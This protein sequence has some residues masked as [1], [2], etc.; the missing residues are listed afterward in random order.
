MLNTMSAPPKIGPATLADLIAI[1]E[2][3]RR[4]EIIDGFLVEKGAATY[5]H[6]LAQG[7]VMAALRPYDRSPG[8]R[9]PGGWWFVTEVEIILESSQVFRPDVTG[10]RRDRLPAEP[11]WPVSTKPDWVCE[12]LS[13]N[14]Q[15]DL[16]KKKR[17]LHR[18]G[19]SHYWIIDPIDATL[20]VYRW[21]PDGYIEVLIADRTQRVRAEPF[22]DIELKVGILFGDDDDEEPQLSPQPDPR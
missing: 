20:S 4:H 8:G 11:D 18:H 3:E 17:A 10:W 13:T 19:V 5:P 9:F 1:P 2:E 15:N 21:H 12:V 16:V 22:G 6:G 14:R 7:R